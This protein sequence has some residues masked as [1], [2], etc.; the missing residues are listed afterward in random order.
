MGLLS[1]LNQVGLFWS[2]ISRWLSQPTGHVSL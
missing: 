1:A 2:K